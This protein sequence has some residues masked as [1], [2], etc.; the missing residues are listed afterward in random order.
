MRRVRSH[1]GYGVS[2]K[3]DGD[4]TAPGPA[5]P[6]LVTWDGGDHDPMSPRS[7]SKARKWIIVLIVS[8]AS[9]CVYDILY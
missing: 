7:F 9:L 4:T 8:N 6:Y 5:D 1:N 2:E 3:N